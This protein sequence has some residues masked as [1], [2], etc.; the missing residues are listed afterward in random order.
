MTGGEDS[1]EVGGGL[2]EGGGCP[3]DGV[4]AAGALSEEGEGVDGF[5]GSSP[6]KIEEGCNEAAFC[7]VDPRAWPCELED[8]TALPEFVEFE[9]AFEFDFDFFAFPKFVGE[10]C[11]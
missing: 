1:E 2:A 6:F 11:N 4:W 10:L 7:E 5:G 3:T 9:D 8:L